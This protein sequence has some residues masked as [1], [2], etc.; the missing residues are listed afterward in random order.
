[1]YIN[2]KIIK[3]RVHMNIMKEERSDDFGTS[4]S[5]LC[6]NYTFPCCVLSRHTK[7]TKALIKIDT[8]I[9]SNH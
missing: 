7:F 4:N 3:V 5:I 8:Y 6:F 2:G 1:M 9:R